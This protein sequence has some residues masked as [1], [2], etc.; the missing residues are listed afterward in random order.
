MLCKLRDAGQ[1]WVAGSLWKPEEAWGRFPQLP[2][3]QPC[4][5]ALISVF[6]SLAD[7][8][9]T[10]LLYAIWFWG[11]ASAVT[12]NSCVGCPHCSPKLGWHHKDL[13]GS[14]VSRVEKTS[15]VWRSTPNTKTD[16]CG[17]DRR[18]ALWGPEGSGCDPQMFASRKIRLDCLW[19]GN[20]WQTD[21]RRANITLTLKNRFKKF[22]VGRL[23]WNF[24]FYNPMTKEEKR[25]N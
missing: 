8:E 18:M 16:H 22:Y 6:W 12:G 4:V 23:W 14:T 24:D 17:G 19:S 25:E 1:A 15:P 9:W 5:W 2:E 13:G 7:W 21:K 11:L 10:S 20:G 3:K